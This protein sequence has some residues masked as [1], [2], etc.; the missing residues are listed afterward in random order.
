MKTTP[1][2]EQIVLRKRL[3][4]DLDWCTEVIANPIKTEVQSNGRI[5]YWGIISEADNRVLRV[6]ILEDGETV[7]N[8]FFDRNFRKQLEREAR[9]S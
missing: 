8:A 2:F 4:I 5:R 6:V 9:L 1:Y 7:H 3:E